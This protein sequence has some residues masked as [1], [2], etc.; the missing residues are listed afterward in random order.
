M[1]KKF[2]GHV[3]TIARGHQGYDLPLQS[4]L[5]TEFLV[6]L[7]AMMTYLLLLSAAGS[8][9]LGNMTHRW[10]SGL[11]NTMTIEIPADETAKT[12]GDRLVNGLAALPSVSSARVLGQ[13]EMQKIL[14]PWLG[15]QP[16]ILADLPLPVL[17]SVELSERTPAVLDDIKGLARRMAPQAIVDAHEDWLSD[18][19]KMTSGL[20]LTAMVVFALILSVTGF[21]IA[22]A[23]R[24]R[25]AIHQRELELLHI[26][27]A[28]DR[29]ITRQFVRYIF[30][31][32]SKGMLVGLAAGLLTMGGFLIL[33]THTGDGVPLITL[34]G[35]EWLLF[36]VVPVVLL[37]I[38][39]LSARQ[40][41]MRVLREMP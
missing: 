27:G 13:D 18:L 34:A 20:R 35:P 38:G 29:Y 25:M 23:V 39:L 5:G 33:A 30:A 28:N 1:F 4:R 9:M 3:F 16:T 24:S 41:A 37:C 26:M 36:L 32:S 15:D 7:I 31:Q 10:T 11:E 14:G 2:H 19:V 22:G 6:L 40:T 21:V 17:I 8:L 12:A